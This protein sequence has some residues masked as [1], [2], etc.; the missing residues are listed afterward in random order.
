MA[1]IMIV[2]VMIGGSIILGNA[3][4]KDGQWIERSNLRYG[5]Q[6]HR[7]LVLVADGYLQLSR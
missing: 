1:M 3:I 4:A 5:R 6:T 7:H 2:M